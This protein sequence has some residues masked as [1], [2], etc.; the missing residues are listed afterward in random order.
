MVVDLSS[1]QLQFE[2]SR[3][4][5][6]FFSCSH[7]LGGFHMNAFSP[8]STG[9]FLAACLTIAT[10]LPTRAQMGT[11]QDP[12]VIVDVSELQAMTNGPAAH[13][14]LG[15]DIDATQTIN[16]NGGSGFLPIG[17]EILPFTGS[18]DGRGHTIS[19]LFISRD[20]KYTS[21]LGYADGATVRN[22]T[23][24]RVDIRS[25]DS[26]TAAV[27]AREVGTTF[28][29]ECHVSGHIVCTGGIFS[30]GILGS[31]SGGT[32]SSCR[33]EIDLESSGY[34]GL[35]AGST[36]ATISGCSA[37]G[38]ISGADNDD[39]I[40]GL[41]GLSYGEI[42]DSRA[43]VTVSGWDRSLGG[44]YGGAVGMNY[45]EITRTASFGDIGTDGAFYVGGFVGSNKGSI[46][47]CFAH[48]NVVDTNSYGG[49]AGGFVG[50]NWDSIVNCYASGAVRAHRGVGGFAAYNEQ[51]GGWRPSISNCFAVGDV[52]GSSEVGSFVGEV[53]G[54]FYVENS[55][56]V[57]ATHENG[58]GFPEP[59]GV[60]AFFRASHSVYDGLPP[61]DFDHTWFL[62]EDQALPVLWTFL[63][64]HRVAI[65]PATNYV[66]DSAGAHRHQFFKGETVHI[67]FLIES[68]T[69]LGAEVWA[70]IAPYTN[71]SSN[72]II[73][74]LSADATLTNGQ[75][76]I[77]LSWPIPAGLPPGYYDLIASV[78]SA[79]NTDHVLDTTYP[80]YSNTNFT[81]DAWLC[82][83]LTN[84]QVYGDV[85]FDD[86]VYESR[87]HLLGGSS[88]VPFNRAKTNWWAPNPGRMQIAVTNS[89]TGKVFLT[90]PAGATN[91]WAKNPEL[92][93][94]HSKF[95]GGTYAAKVRFDNSPYAIG[96]QVNQAFWIQN[97][98]SFG[99]RP[100]LYSECDFEFYSHWS[101]LDFV[102][103]ESVSPRLNTNEHYDAENVGDLASVG[104][105]MNVV[106]KQ[107]CVFRVYNGETGGQ[108]PGAAFT[109]S[110]GYA[111]E[112]LMQIFLSIGVLSGHMTTGT[113]TMES[114]WVYFNEETDLDWERI[115]LD[116]GDFRSLEWYR[117]D[118]VPDVEPR[119]YDHDHDGMTDADEIEAGTDPTD[120]SS[121]FAVLGV[122]DP[123]G[124]G[125]IAIR[126]SSVHGKFYDVF[127][128]LD[129]MSGFS[130]VTSGIPATA[131]ENVYTDS[132]NGGQST[133][134]Q[135]RLS[136]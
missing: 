16:W 58:I 8:A 84:I 55:Y 31:G 90:Q 118:S 94:R 62:E 130:S 74:Y 128:S 28:V 80:G 117:V 111:P 23:L 4:S 25:A 17:T 54:T 75:N 37:K 127:R 103:W 45:G 9:L 43:T 36:H 106:P 68:S 61:W 47:N 134:Y 29:Q 124:S 41:V 71:H 15:A 65:V 19:N 6:A 112:Y 56:Y 83:P 38:M 64:P 86:F 50:R 133:F 66:H 89:Q 97:A 93:T 120:P 129:L 32:I 92:Q 30:G 114:D 53:W 10:A 102:A 35:I 72:A 87:E 67:P 104:L 18:L 39:N 57:D 22:L 136:P 79:T 99:D 51:I 91:D 69:D 24:A 125:E 132:V 70:N 88:W 82:G 40:G 101:F 96:D 13:Y 115:V 126:W 44:D 14:A 49:G 42:S 78:R 12:F 21:L 63:P 105:V 107:S 116:V 113:T 3:L 26:W 95:L 20:D 122:D 76:L 11:E 81:E 34:S 52:A 2:N 33:V 131:P 109:A 5:Q 48:G 59:G 46:S 60:S 100:E 1:A 135:I 98:S 119:R 73:A 27:I 121:V 123:T 110:S 77:E 85:F 7:F 108:L